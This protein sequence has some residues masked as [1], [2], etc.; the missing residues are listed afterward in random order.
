MLL[1]L[2]CGKLPI[3]KKKEFVKMLSRLA[4]MCFLFK[5]LSLAERCFCY[6]SGSDHGTQ[7]H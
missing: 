1:S 3:C 2:K 5:Y 4:C 6:Y 7:L